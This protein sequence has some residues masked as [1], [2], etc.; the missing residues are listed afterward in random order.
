VKEDSI[1]DTKRKL[2]K[3]VDLHWQELDGKYEGLIT[4]WDP[5]TM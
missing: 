1:I 2:W 4:L 3:E 5:S